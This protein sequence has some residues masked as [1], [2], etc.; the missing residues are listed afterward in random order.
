MTGVDTEIIATTEK[1]LSEVFGGEVRVEVK[2]RLGSGSRS[3]VLRCR[4]RTSPEDA[5]MSVVV[6]Q[7]LA[8]DDDVYDPDSLEGPAVRLFNDWAGV[9]FLSDVTD[10]TSLTPRFY[11]GDSERGLVVIEDLGDGERLDELLL[12]DAPTDA[13]VGLIEFATVLGRMHALTVG[14]RAEYERVRNGLGPRWQSP[15][16]AEGLLIGLAQACNA[17]GVALRREVADEMEA[18]AALVA[19]PGPFDVYTHGALCPDNSRFVGGELRLLNF[20][21]GDFRHALRDGVYGRI[22]FPTCW[23]V[24]RIPSAVMR[25]MENAYRAELVKGCP[26][27]TDDTLF[28]RAIVE[29]CTHWVIGMFYSLTHGLLEERDESGISTVQQRLLLRLDVLVKATEEFSYL[30]A[31]GATVRDILAKLRATWTDGEEMPYYP[32]FR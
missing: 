16:T 10:G 17:V 31:I 27:A 19:N 1:I 2:E 8:H 25:E 32:A 13:E 7:V 29:A 18:V 26:E 23:C 11:G 9:Q 4:V 14:K 6:K 30:P 3:N 20:E 15:S 21:F 28:Y 5:P 24:N 12:G 22:Y